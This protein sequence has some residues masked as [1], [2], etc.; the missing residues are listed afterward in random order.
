MVRPGQITSVEIT[1]SDKAFQTELEITSA[2]EQN[3]QLLISS[4][5]RIPLQIKTGSNLHVLLSF[6]FALS[7]TGLIFLKQRKKT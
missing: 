4:G 7:L 2:P 1:G 6:I 3:G 5:V